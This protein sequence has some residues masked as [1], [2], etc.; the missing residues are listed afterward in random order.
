MRP[1]PWRTGSANSSRSK[2]RSS[3]SWTRF[4]TSPTRSSG[5]WRRTRRPRWTGRARHAGRRPEPLRLALARR[6]IP[7]G[8]QPQVLLAKLGIGLD[9]GG[10]ERNA[11]DRADLLAL[12]RVEM[13]DSLGAAVGIDDVD[14]RPLRDR[15]VRAF[16]LADVAVDALVGDDQGHA[17]ASF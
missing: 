3:I 10:V 6:R 4:I 5:Y 8:G 15:A 14:L 16:R 2:R 7:R 9:M 12:R 13:A 17:R 1:I 11:V